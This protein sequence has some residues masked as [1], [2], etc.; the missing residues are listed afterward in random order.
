MARFGHVNVTSHDWRRLAAFYTDVFGCVFVP[1]ER[2]IRSA[3]P[4]RGDRPARRASDRGPP[5]PAGARR[6]RAD[7]R[8]LL[9]R[10]ARRPIPAR[11]STVRAGA[12]IAFQ[13]PDVPAAVEAVV[14]AGGGRHGE[15]VTT[16]T[17]DGRQVTWVYTTDP[18]GQSR[19]TAGLVGR[20][21]RVTTLP[22][23]RPL[24]TIVST[25]GSRPSSRRAAT[26]SPTDSGRPA[27]C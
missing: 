5:A 13:V 26:T 19:R 24:P 7:A 22:V 21:G 18:D 25:A 9:V 20:P 10:R 6:D 27:C 4:G 15:I 2:D 17:T 8:D 14:A 12:I 3:G 1:P 23:G 11:G 16:R